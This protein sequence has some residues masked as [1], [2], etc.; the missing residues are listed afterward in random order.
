MKKKLITQKLLLLV[1]KEI[2]LRMFELFLH[3]LLLHQVLERV[4]V[5]LLLVQMEEARER[6]LE[7]VHLRVRLLLVRC[8]FQIQDNLG[9]GEIDCIQISMGRG[10]GV[11]HLIESRFDFHVLVGLELDLLA[12]TIEVSLVRSLVECRVLVFFEQCFHLRER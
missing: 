7:D 3:D 6:L 12:E 5:V 10:R 11:F 8:V 2:E 9:G 1:G 4:G